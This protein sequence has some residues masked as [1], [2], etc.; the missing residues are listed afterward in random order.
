VEKQKQKRLPGGNG[1]PLVFDKGPCT[2]SARWFDIGADTARIVGRLVAT[3][4]DAGIKFDNMA[5]LGSD[6]IFACQTRKRIDKP[7]DRIGFLCHQKQQPSD[8][9]RQREPPYYRN[10]DQRNSFEGTVKPIPWIS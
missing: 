1:G 6:S 7:V 2:F 10:I 3:L 8:G 9:S 4:D 5:T